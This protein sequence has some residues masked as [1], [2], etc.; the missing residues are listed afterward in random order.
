MFEEQKT[1]NS[2]VKCVYCLFSMAVMAC[3]IRKKIV[4]Q[5]KADGKYPYLLLAEI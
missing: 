2:S 1:G 5:L 4:L 3:K